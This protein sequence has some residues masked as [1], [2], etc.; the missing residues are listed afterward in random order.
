M[1]GENTFF[2]KRIN[3]LFCEWARENHHKTHFG[4]FPQDSLKGA[5][6]SFETDHPDLVVVANDFKHSKNLCDHIRGSEDARHTGI[7]FFE[8]DKPGLSSIESLEVGADDFVSKTKDKREILARA[9]AVIRLKGMTDELRKANHRLEILSHTDELTG[10]Y[11]MRYLENYMQEAVK[12]CQNNM[13]SFGVVMVDLDSFKSIN[14]NTNH[15]VGSFIISE[16]G[17]LLRLTGVFGERSCIARYGGD[18]YIAVVK[19]ENASALK[20]QAE[21]LRKL[22]KEAVFQK[23]GFEIKITLSIGACF[24]EKGY[25]GDGN[26]AVKVA[27][28]MLYKSKENGRDQVNIS[29]LGNDVDFDHICRAHL[30]NRDAS[31]KDN[32]VTRFNYIKVLK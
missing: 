7:I 31:R 4:I 15:L 13:E 5:L 19:C 3:H 21:H 12:D 18:E 17:K 26:N 23:D 10:L 28:L 11:N 14:D 8:T 30:V 20:A 29:T 32:H 1:V 16:V 27:D 25:K 9:L 2:Q 22:L 24:V 6:T